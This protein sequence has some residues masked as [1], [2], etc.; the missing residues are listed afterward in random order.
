[1]RRCFAAKTIAS[2]L[3]PQRQGVPQRIYLATVPATL[4]S[5]ADKSFLVVG[6]LD[7][8]TLI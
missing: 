5:L 4:D 2:A 1:M 3:F 8:H 6:E 7:F